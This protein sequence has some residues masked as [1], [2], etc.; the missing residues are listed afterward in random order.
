MRVL[1]GG[2]V[3]SATVGRFTTSPPGVVAG[4]IFST[5]CRLMVSCKNIRLSAGAANPL[6]MSRSEQ[7]C[8]PASL[9]SLDAGV[10]GWRGQECNGWTVHYEP[11][12]RRCGIDLLHRVPLDGQLQEHP[13]QR[14]C[15]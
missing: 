4:S 10:A 6:S 3:K 15:G 5:G 11:S 1:R 7:A 12:G 8:G 14:R 13:S 9:A 2:A